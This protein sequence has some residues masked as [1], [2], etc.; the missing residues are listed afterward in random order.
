MFFIV[1]NERPSRLARRPFLD[2]VMFGRPPVLFHG[3]DGNVDAAQY[4]VAHAS[5]HSANGA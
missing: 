2:K 1:K 3:Q 5:E 4:A